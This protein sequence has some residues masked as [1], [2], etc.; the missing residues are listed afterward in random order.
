M[1]SGRTENTADFLR[2]ITSIIY[3][4]APS[5]LAS[6]WVQYVIRLFVHDL[7]HHSGSQ[8]EAVLEQ[9][10]FC[11][12]LKFPIRYNK[13][14]KIDAAINWNKWEDA[15]SLLQILI[16]WQKYAQNPSFA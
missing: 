13:L 4:M 5:G 8:A 2:W 3:N 6:R 9:Q 14:R 15:N 10:A 12:V 1:D 16:F 11:H 7:Q